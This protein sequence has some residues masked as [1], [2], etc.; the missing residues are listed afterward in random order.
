DYKNFVDNP[1]YRGLGASQLGWAW[2]TMH[3]GVYQPVSWMFLELQYTV[4]G[5]DGRWYHLV[6]LL[7]HA[8]D[9]VLLF[10]LSVV[11][12]RR[13]WPDY[14]A[15]NPWTCVLSSG[16]AV[17]WYA[18]HPLRVEAVAWASCQPYLVCTFFYLLAVL[19]YLRAFPA[20]E[21]RQTRWIA[22]SF[23]MCV[24]AL[25]A[26]AVAVSIPFVL[27]LLDIYPLRRVGSV[28]SGWFG[29]AAKRIWLE[30]LPFLAV[31][32]VFMVIAVAAKRQETLVEA[33]QLHGLAAWQ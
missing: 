18:V 24:L 13:L 5:L 31:S 26:K 33:M 8:I 27:L 10:V 15:T 20:G 4:F 22:L 23:G 28:E 25:L 12:L 2:T 14:Y 16:L 1:H 3:L 9:M 30:K 32:A 29:V 17:V 6:S 11:L 21:A 19:C 7:L